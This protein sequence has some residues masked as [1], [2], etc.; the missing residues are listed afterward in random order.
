MTHANNESCDF[1]SFT[2]PTD[3]EMAE[4]RVKLTEMF[5]YDPFERPP[6]PAPEPPS[7]AD[8]WKE[9]ATVAGVYTA[10]GTGLVAMAMGLGYV[11]WD[12]QPESAYHH[13][14]TPPAP[15]TEPESK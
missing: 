12:T 4:A 14:D 5:G 6:Q 11:L 10:V 15:L 7:R 3:E 8:K 9:R 2:Y 1:S 13:N